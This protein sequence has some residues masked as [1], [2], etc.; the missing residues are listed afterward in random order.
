MS[1]S[2]NTISYSHFTKL[3]YYAC[4]FIL[5]DQLWNHLVH[6]YTLYIILIIVLILSWISVLFLNNENF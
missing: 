1:G 3:I 5:V 4:A 6:Q 2:V